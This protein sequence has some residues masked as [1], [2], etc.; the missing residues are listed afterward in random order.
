MRQR[1]SLKETLIIGEVSGQQLCVALPDGGGDEA[2]GAARG[3][4]GYVAKVTEAGGAAKDEHYLIGVFHSEGVVTAYDSP[5]N[6]ARNPTRAA[7]RSPGRRSK[8]RSRYWPGSGRGSI[9]PS[10]LSE[11]PPAIPVLPPELWRVG[12]CTCKAQ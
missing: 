1:D 5:A 7:Y 4:A 8:S 2:V 11:S 10:S 6:H 9:C 3:I 12:S